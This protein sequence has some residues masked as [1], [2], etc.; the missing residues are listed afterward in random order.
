MKT[1]SHIIKTAHELCKK[2]AP[3]GMKGQRIVAIVYD[4]KYIEGIGIASL[5]THPMQQQQSKWAYLHAETD[6]IVHA[7][8]HVTSPN[9]SFKLSNCSIYVH[10]I[11]PSGNIGLAK[12]CINCNTVLTQI[13]GITDIHW[14]ISEK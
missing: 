7:L 5:K 9:R 11:T 2:V 8:R 1:P 10:R 14:S 12:P 4:K 6:A 3:V 13:W